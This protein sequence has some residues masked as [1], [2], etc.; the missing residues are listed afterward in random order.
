MM[1]G[2]VNGKTQDHLPFGYRA[3]MGWPFDGIWKHDLFKNDLTPYDP[4]DLEMIETTIS[5]K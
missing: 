2:L 5:K 3:E 4:A 1:W